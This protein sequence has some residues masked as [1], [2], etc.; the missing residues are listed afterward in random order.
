ME[1]GGKVKILNHTIHYEHVSDGKLCLSLGTG[2][3]FMY[4]L[5]YIT[6]LTFFFLGG[7]DAFTDF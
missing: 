5:T 7:G 6:I 1:G 4:F 3:N 2:L